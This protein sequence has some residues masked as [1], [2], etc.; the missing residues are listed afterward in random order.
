MMSNSWY[1]VEKTYSYILPTELLAGTIK[2]KREG[3]RMHNLKFKIIVSKVD[4]KQSDYGH[5]NNCIKDFP[6]YDKQIDYRSKNL[7]TKAGQDWTG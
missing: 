2:M 4:D 6:N 5:Q 3:L 7:T 1:K